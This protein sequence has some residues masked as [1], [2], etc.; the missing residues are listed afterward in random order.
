MEKLFEISANMVSA[1]GLSFQRFLLHQMDWKQRLI[2]IR[3]ARGVGKTTLMLQRMKQAFGK[4][5]MQALYVS[6]DQLWFSQNTICD[7]VDYHYKHGGTHLFLDEVHRYP[8]SHWQQELKNIYDSYPGYSLVLTS[9]SMIQLNAKVA[10]LSRRI[11]IYDLP[12]LSFREYLSFEKKGAFEAVSLSDI[13]KHHTSLASKIVSKHKILPLFE[14]YLKQGY[15][16]FYKEVSN[17]LYLKRVERT[18]STVVDIDIP[19]AAD[20]EYESRLKIKRLLMLLAEQVPFSP[21]ITKLCMEL[22]LSRNQLIKL[23]GLLHDAGIVR[24]L[25]ASSSKFKDNIKPNKLLFDNPDIMYALSDQANIGTLRETFAATMLS[26]DHA[27][28][29][30]RQGDLHIDKKITFE[31]GGKKKGYSQI[32]DLPDSYVL[33]DNLEIGHGNKIPLWLIG[34]LY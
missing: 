27:L 24:L 30:P 3:G 9:S 22:E 4:K 17:I 31:I 7:L 34:F 14:T 2:M 29:S 15:Y 8:H 32:A 26:K 19:S 16:P 13:L 33:S 21:N 5:P 20:I 25:Y 1:T 23:L 18:I 6:L 12:G 28:F 10:D 11:D